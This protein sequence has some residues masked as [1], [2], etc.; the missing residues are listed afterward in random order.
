M[1]SFNAIYGRIGKIDNISILIFLLGTIL[2]LQHS[3]M[4]LE[5]FSEDKTEKNKM[6][7]TFERA[8]MKIFSTFDKNVL[9]S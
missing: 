8:G 4:E 7:H 3:F 9:A 2:L 1:S 5:I 6:Q